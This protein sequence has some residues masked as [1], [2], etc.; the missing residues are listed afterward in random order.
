MGVNE[1][2]AVF[3]RAYSVRLLLQVLC[4]IV[5][6]IKKV[7]TGGGDG[8]DTTVAYA[9]ITVV[10]NELAI[11]SAPFLYSKIKSRKVYLGSGLAEKVKPVY[12]ALA[13]LVGILTLFA[14]A[15]AATLIN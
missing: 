3:R 7:P 12:L 14:F 8:L 2:T 1:A 13:A 4:Y 10:I 5:L 6:T 9:C 15:P 11:L